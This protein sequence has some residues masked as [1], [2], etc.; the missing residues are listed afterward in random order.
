M[1]RS[2]QYVFDNAT[3]DVG[4]MKHLSRLA[5]ELMTTVIKPLGEALTLLPAGVD[6]EGQTAG[7]GFALARHVPLPAEP[8]AASVV[9][10]EK[11]SEL[12]GRLGVAAADD[13]APAQ[14][15][16]AARNVAEMPDRLLGKSTIERPSAEATSPGH[17]AD[18]TSLPLSTA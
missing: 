6:Y 3:S 7:A 16:S 10:R 12:A 15:K 11:L 8:S 2:L 14:L 4:L 18:G 17:G 1:L 5:L 9:V 13:R